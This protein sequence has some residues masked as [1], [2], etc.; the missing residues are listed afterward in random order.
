MPLITNLP[1]LILPQRL[2]AIKSLEILLAI[3]ESSTGESIASLLAMIPA[4]FPNLSKLHL[5]LDGEIYPKDAEGRRIPSNEIRQRAAAS[6]SGLLSYVDG[7][8]RAYGPRYVDCDVALAGKVF[9]PLVNEARRRGD[10]MCQD[11]SWI[12]GGFWRSV[13]EEY[14]KA[15]YW[16]VMGQ[17]DA[18]LVRGRIPSPRECLVSRNH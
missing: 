6:E 14:P 5:H 11:R 17:D 10:R 4:S 8:V 12:F 15:G 13:P 7:M 3:P 2:A 16:V 18:I 9:Q 1:S